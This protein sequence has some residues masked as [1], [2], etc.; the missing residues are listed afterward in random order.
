MVE[1][2]YKLNKNKDSIQRGYSRE[3]IV[4]KPVAPYTIVDTLEGGEAV[5][6]W[7]P[8]F[9]QNPKEIGQQILRGLNNG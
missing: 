4:I 3:D 9:V 1:K 2:R 8:S 7:I 5:I 6:A